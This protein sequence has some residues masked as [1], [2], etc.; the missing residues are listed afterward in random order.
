MPITE[1][2][3]KR[4]SL[5]HDK[6][7]GIALSAVLLQLCLVFPF[8]LQSQ[9]IPA[10]PSFEITDSGDNNFTGW[11]QFG[12]TGS[13]TLAV[14]GSLA[15]KVS[16]QNSGDLNV[17]GYWQLLEGEPGEQWQVSG[18]VLNS[19]VSPLTGGSFAL[20]N[21]EWR[22]STGGLISYD[23]FTVAN[24][25]SP[26]DEY[27]P[28]SFLSSPAPAGTAYIHFLLGVLQTAGDPA[29]DVIYDQ[30]NCYSTSYPTIDDMQ[31]TDFPGGRTLNFSDRL[32]RVKGPGWYGPGNN[33]FSDSP[34]SVWVDAEDRLHLTIKQISNVWNSTEVTLSEALGYGD[35]IF[36]TLG[37]LD[38]LDV[39]AVLGLF[40][41]QYG[42]SG[43]QPGSWWNPYNEIDVEYSRWGNAGNQIGQFVAQPWDWT[44][45][46][47]RYD[48]V[49]G[50]QQLSSHAFRWLPDRV[51]FRSWYGGP[52]DESPANL[53]SAW[54]YYGPHVP[55]PEQ[56][57]VHL[58][59]WYIATP[60][61]AD[62]EVILDEFTFIPTGVQIPGIPQNVALMANG[63]DLTLSWNDDPTVTFWNV[64]SSDDPASGF[65]LR[66]TVTGN[67]CTLVGEALSYPHRFYYVTANN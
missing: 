36:T 14:H 12:V 33:Y 24:A 39:R 44:G 8:V 57:R 19:S 49:F 28:F 25:A 43:T 38:Q 62:L 58:N 59:L 4:K 48:A 13:S 64:W 15:A 18:H 34:Q 6:R 45:N 31:W 21:V 52:N 46:M 51:E 9:V 2:T 63:N 47:F 56:P 42:P 54:T 22:S 67:S 30:V 50:A 40:L 61:A 32:W 7:H 65:T 20:V 3:G 60:L 55:L 26:V 16:G 29:P 27:L 5:H 41:W 66:D 10:N 35:Y 53:I 17:S 37:A 1:I 11:N 23:T